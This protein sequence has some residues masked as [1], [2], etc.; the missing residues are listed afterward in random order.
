[1]LLVLET[2]I[3]SR[4][5]E[6]DVPLQ[7]RHATRVPERR[8]HRRENAVVLDRLPRESTHRARAPRGLLSL[9]WRGHARC[10]THEERPNETLATS[11][12]SRECRTM[13]VEESA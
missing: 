6:S 12:C 1:A 9:L 8:H 2:S 13:L 5:R 11:G 7:L 4:A 10:W 3:P